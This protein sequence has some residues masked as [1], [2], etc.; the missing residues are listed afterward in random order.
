MRPTKQTI[1][2]DPENGKHGNC[3]SAVLASL[4]HVNIEDIPIFTE[5]YPIWQQQLNAW[6]RPYGLAYIQV[7]E[8]SKWCRDYGIE[9]CYH[10]LGGTTER[11]VDISHA[12]VGRDGEFLFDPHP[13]D[14]GLSE[15]E[16]AG[17]FIALEPWRM[18]ST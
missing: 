7:S 8:F 12:C 5:P 17:I 1:L 13:D 18:R 11:S 4:L 10:E 6:L 16:A 2:H 14:T 9:G 3:L 15:I